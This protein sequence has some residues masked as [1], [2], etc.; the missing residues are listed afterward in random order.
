MDHE[1][2]RKNP[3]SPL[4]RPGESPGF[5]RWIILLAVLG[6][7]AALIAPYF[8][9][10][11]TPQM[12]YSD[13]KDRVS[14]GQVEEV[15][16]KA[17][18]QIT[19]KLKN[20]EEFST[21]APV[22]VEDPELIPSL[23][24]RGVRLKVQPPSN[25]ALA[26][27]LSWVIFVALLVGFW[28]WVSR[29]AQ[30]QMAGIMNI[31]RSRAKVYSTEKPQTTFD[32]V[33]GYKGVK[34]EVSEVIEFLKNPKRFKE[35]GARIPKGIL[36]VGPPGTGKTLIARA[37][38]G[39]AGV[40]FIS[41]T[42]SDFMEM[43]VGV[44]AA[45]VRDLFQTARKN[46]PAI[47]FIDEIDSI[48]RKRG[49]G[50]GGGHDEREQT[51]NQMLAEMDGF[52]TTEGV[53]VMAATNRPDIL[54]PALLR[55]GRFDRQIV[56]PLPTQEERLEILKVHTKGK[57]LAADVDLEVLARGTPGFSGAD[58]SNLT[59]EAALFAVRRGRKEI[60]AEDFDDA[61]DRVIMGRKRESMAISDEEKNVIAVHEA[62]HALLAYLLPHAD[63]LHKVTILP[64]GMALGATHQLPME[65][66]HIYQKEYILDRLAV[67]LGGRAAEMLVF[68]TIST[69]AS[70]D[71]V[72][73]TELAR[74]MVREWG[75]SDRLG[76]MAWGEQ[77]MV[78]LG[79]DLVKAHEYS[80]ETA[81]VID[82]EVQRILEEQDA[83]AREVI[84]KNREALDALAEELKAKETISG[85]EAEKVIESALATKSK[86]AP[87]GPTE[88]EPA[89]D[90]EPAAESETASGRSA[91]SRRASQPSGSGQPAV[92]K[93]TAAEAAEVHGSSIGLGDQSGTSARESGT[94]SAGTGSDGEPISELAPKTGITQTQRPPLER[95][96]T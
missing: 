67:S 59:N 41:I 37:V 55:P 1:S 34:E 25:N 78:F 87:S 26:N 60:T 72:S 83:R 4:Q 52:E 17:D 73:A 85:A 91:S 35:L 29:R 23:K 21:A 61:R 30:G 22:A 8:M 80:D 94:P 18:G 75:M 96:A 38:A 51:L 43:F 70:N 39:E 47:V 14:Q 63:P 71:L 95:P 27:I 65:E 13:F 88:S 12:A 33:A 20:G 69:G 24:E 86:H 76:P 2:P 19:G 84:S 54:D 49:T 53:V 28:V 42:G 16:I 79:E 56:I 82:E 15:T 66:K 44:G 6:F 11:P 40:P 50:L 64:M 5:P 92:V 31:G 77:G 7:V 46:A 45:R 32:D 36:L 58:L 90:F 81:R 68:G 48:G 93:A 74:K 10:Q 57:R 89:T 62:G 9:A 3:Q